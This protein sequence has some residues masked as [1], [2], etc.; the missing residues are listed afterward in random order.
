MNLN[1]PEQCPILLEILWNRSITG[2]AIVAEDGRF[3]RANPAF[4]RLTEYT[5]YELR[6]KRFQDITDP[7]DVEADVEMAK[8]VA[9]GEPEGY[10]MTKSYITK[11]RDFLPILLRVTG[12][13][14]NGKF[15]YFIKEIAPLERRNSSPPIKPRTRNLLSIIKE[16]WIQI[17]AGFAVIGTFIDRLLN[18]YLK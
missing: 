14:M 9:N 8:M 6:Q 10:D 16:Y 15:T 18:Y 12:L 2:L 1:D 3:L 7:S 17:T 5:E 4:C 11:S 13:R